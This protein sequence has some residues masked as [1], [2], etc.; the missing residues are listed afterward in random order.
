MSATTSRSGRDV[1]EQVTET[2]DRGCQ[3]PAGAGGHPHDFLF[4]L[5]QDGVE[6]YQ[7]GRAG[8]V[9]LLMKPDGVNTVGLSIGRKEIINNA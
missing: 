4:A 3:A 6:R 5:S 7:A 8:A 1:G 2:A 9:D